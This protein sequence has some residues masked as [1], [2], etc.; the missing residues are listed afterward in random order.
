MLKLNIGCGNYPILKDGWV[1]LDCKGK[2]QQWEKG[3]YKYKIKLINI[4]YFNW[5]IPSE[6]IDCIVMSHV[7]NQVKQHDKIFEECYRVLKK[8]GVFRI[9]DDDNENEESKYFFE[10][11]EHTVTRMFP[12][13]IKMV[14][15]G[16]GFKV[17]RVK[18]DETVFVDKLICVNNHPELKECDKF[19]LECVK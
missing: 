12:G 13:L 1:N 18:S 7:L 3:K 16:I 19:F 4:E 14:L 17:K 15:E 5:D 2:F 8:G 9:T 6:T 11:H 10:P